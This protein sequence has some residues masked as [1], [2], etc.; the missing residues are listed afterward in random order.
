MSSSTMLAF[1]ALCALLLP[2]RVQAA[3]AR[4]GFASFVRLVRS[5]AGRDTWREA[6]E[7]R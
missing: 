1:C 4:A 5:I 2:I 7:K 6:A 3:G